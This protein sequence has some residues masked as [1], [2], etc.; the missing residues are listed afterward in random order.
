MGSLLGLLPKS[1]HSAYVPL[2]HDLSQA[3]HEASGK[4]DDDEGLPNQRGTRSGFSPSLHKRPDETNVFFGDYQPLSVIIPWM[5]LMQ[6]LFSAH[7]SIIDIGK[8][9]EGKSILG[10]RVGVHPKIKGKPTKPRRTILV[11]G[12]SHAREWVSVSSVIY[13]AYGFITS[14]GKSKEMTKMI[15]EFDWIFVPTINP[16]GY[17]K[18]WEDDRLWRKNTQATS[19][20]FCQGYDID[21]SFPFHWDGESTRGNPCSESFAGESP[22]QAIEA[23]SLSDWV[24]NETAN[25]NVN[26]VGFLDLHSYSQQILYPYAFSC[27]ET[28][29]TIETLEEIGLGLARAIHRQSR[30][31]YTVMS[32]CQGSVRPVSTHEKDR[33][34]N[35]IT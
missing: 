22:L 30:A 15:E 6:S 19:V 4:H 2:I 7:V 29:P 3:I 33:R 18:T 17:T 25:N 34:A 27:M 1:M 12:G 32:A 24:K 21:R 20:Q 5:R 9:S 35:K 13:A 14:Y 23:L 10:L 26:F 8:S 28:P 16:D 11:T 31:S